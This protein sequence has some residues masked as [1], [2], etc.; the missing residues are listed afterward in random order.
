MRSGVRVD[1][2][3]TYAEVVYGMRCVFTFRNGV[4]AES[5]EGNV[6]ES[7]AEFR[8]RFGEVTPTPLQLAAW[9]AGRTDGVERVEVL[10]H[11]GHGASAK[12]KERPRGA[13]R[14]TQR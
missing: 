1:A 12:V 6:L 10:A 2:S 11:I 9:L 4:T 7:V 14:R 3:W 5:A 13:G 8:K